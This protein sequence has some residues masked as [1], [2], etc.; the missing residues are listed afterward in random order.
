MGRVTSCASDYLI[1]FGVASIQLSVVAR[2]ALPILVM[3]LFGLVYCLLLFWFVGRRLCRTFWFERSLFVY[4]WATGVV[5][6][7]ITLLRGVAPAFRSRP[8][9]DYGLASLFIAPVEIALLVLVPPLVAQGW[10]AVPAAVLVALF[11]TCLALSAHLI[12]WFR[13]PATAV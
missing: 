10:I 1:G 6:P 3:A 2:H 9:E 11:V 13:A 8:L 12:G 4:G 7:S 5:A